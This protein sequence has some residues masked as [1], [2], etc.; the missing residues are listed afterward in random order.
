MS[1]AILA[2]ARGHCFRVWS[3]TSL[4]S[5]IKRTHTKASNSK[6]FDSEILLAKNSGGGRTVGAVG[7][8]GS[9]DRQQSL[10]RTLSLVGT[11]TQDAPSAPR[12]VCQTAVSGPVSARLNM[13]GQVVEWIFGIKQKTKTADKKCPCDK[14][15]IHVNNSILESDTQGL[16]NFSGSGVDPL[17]LFRRKVVP[18][19]THRPLADESGFL[20][21]PIRSLVQVLRHAP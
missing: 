15:N 8:G 18:P 14:N 9:G 12:P 4:V 16:Q 20:G 10:G 21:P 17:T 3:N 1:S 19:P 2:C 6:N 13:H 7:G 11:A 5:D